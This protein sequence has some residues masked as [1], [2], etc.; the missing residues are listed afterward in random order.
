MATV[1]DTL[2]VEGSVSSTVQGRLVGSM[3]SM[4]VASEENEG[5]VI[6]YDGP[7]GE[8]T[9]LSF[10]ICRR[11]S[12]GFVWS[13]III[14]MDIVASLARGAVPKDRRIN[15]KSLHSDITLTCA[16]IGAM[17]A[18]TEIP[19]RVSQLSNDGVFITQDCSTM[20]NYWT[21]EQMKQVLKPYARIIRVDEFPEDDA[22]DPNAFYSVLQNGSRKL[23][24]RAD[25]EW[26]PVA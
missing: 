7:A 6:L 13:P 2:F 16:D 10:Y 22:I 12:S 11:E 24:Y 9:P 25:D 15:N 19:T 23:F 5:F 4:P 18:S 14:A 8:F 20:S 3:D 1:L 21:K 26:I 17:P